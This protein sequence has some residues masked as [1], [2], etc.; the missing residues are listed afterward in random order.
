MAQLV[1]SANQPEFQP[2]TSFRVGD[3]PPTKGPVQTQPGWSSSSK[4]RHPAARWAS[5]PVSLVFSR[6]N[7]FCLRDRPRREGAPL[8]TLDAAL[9]TAASSERYVVEPPRPRID[10]LRTVDMSESNSWGQFAGL[11]C[12]TRSAFLDHQRARSELKGLMPEDAKEASGHGV[13]AKRSKSNAI[14][15]DLLVQEDDHAAV[16]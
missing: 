6:H 11:F 16:E 7:A 14:S 15:F 2:A 13:R 4:A 12:A 3:A 5:I 10:A 9:A 8:A 1:K